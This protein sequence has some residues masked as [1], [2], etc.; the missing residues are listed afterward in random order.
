MTKYKSV[1]FDLDGT[2]ADTSL[3]ITN[4]HRYTLHQM[5]KSLPSDKVLY[6]VIG[7]PLM[8]T[9]RT[10]FGFDSVNVKIAVDIY[11][12]HYG[13][14]GIYQASLYDG[15]EDTLSRLS[16]RGYIMG[17]ATLKKEEFAVR[18]LKQLGI[19]QYFSTIKGMDGLDHLTKKDIIIR[20]MNEFELSKG[21]VVLVG[22]S[23]FDSMGAMEAGIDFIGVTYGFGFKSKQE[24]Y[25]SNAAYAID[26]PEELDDFLGSN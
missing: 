5:G 1:L 2:L 4:C 23:H 22:D 19:A 26:R 8:E 18:I 11:R 12:K 24:V 20:C 9:Y 6:E 3:G 25:G 10:R 14:T 13:E 21:Q 15:M 16:Q 7:A 17:V